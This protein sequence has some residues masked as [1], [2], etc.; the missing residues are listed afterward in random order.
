MG[1]P[2]LKKVR[3]DFERVYERQQNFLDKLGEH[4]HGELRMGLA[5]VY[6]ALGAPE[7][8]KEQLEAVVKE[9]PDTEYATEAQ[10]WLKAPASK[11]LSHNCIGCHSE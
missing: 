11:K 3:E 8:S 7:K 10:Q 5:D 9:L 6:R 2:V 1:I 4:P